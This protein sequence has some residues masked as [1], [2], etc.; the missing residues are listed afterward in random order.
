M[1]MKAGMWKV[2]T[3]MYRAAAA[4]LSPRSGSHACPM[5]TR[6]MARYLALSKKA[7][8]WAGLGAEAAAGAFALARDEEPG[9]D[10]AA[11]PGTDSDTVPALATTS[12]SRSVPECPARA[13]LRSGP[14]PAGPAAGP[15]RPV[16][17]GGPEALRRPDDRALR[18]R[19][20]LVEPR[21]TSSRL[22]GNEAIM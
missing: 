12:A 15:A 22:T 14:R 9:E 1:T 21:W 7:S 6:T 13:L 10:A 20:S 2:Y 17:A 5:A 11:V 4:L 3:A 19:H 18:H 8:R 16:C